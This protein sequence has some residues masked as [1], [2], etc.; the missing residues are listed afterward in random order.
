MVIIK[1]W[2]LRN[3]DLFNITYYNII[4]SKYDVGNILT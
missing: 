4:L 3:N 2:G 1:Q